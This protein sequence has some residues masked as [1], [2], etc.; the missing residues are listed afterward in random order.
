M[1]KAATPYSPDLIRSIIAVMGGVLLYS[2]LDQVLETTLVRAMA[3]GPIADEAGYFAVR[4][5]PTALAAKVIF[6]GLVAVLAG[7]LSAKIAG[8][9]E[10]Q[11]GLASA[12]IQTASMAWGYTVGEYAALTPLWAR[13]A[14][15]LTTAPIMIGGAAIRRKARL[16]LDD[17]DAAAAN[18]NAGGTA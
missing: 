3:T 2:V 18:T 16:A 5:Q 11:H 1:T 9:E 14:L 8:A 13:I 15:V 6:G 10:I 17:A 12:A 4:N 7:Y